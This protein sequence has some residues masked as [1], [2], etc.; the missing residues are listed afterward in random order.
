MPAT[1]AKARKAKGRALEQWVADQ[2]REK[3]LDDRAN[4]SYGS[5]S[6][7]R[8]KADVWT[9]MMILGQNAGI[10]CKHADSLQ[11]QAWWEQTKKL[12]DLSREPILVAKQTSWRYENVVAVVYLDT[13][14]D[15]LAELKNYEDGKKKVGGKWVTRETLGSY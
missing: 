10:E 14:L 2:I 15:L 1:S 11:L 4:P 5:G 6:G 7:T 13:L 12:Q 8:E 3:G 9:S